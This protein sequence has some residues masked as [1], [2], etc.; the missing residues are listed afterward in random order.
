M[1]KFDKFDYAFKIRDKSNPKDWIAAEN[2]TIL[3]A[4]K[5]LG[6]SFLEDLAAR[7]RGN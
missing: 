5:D 1:Q 3:P 6:S 2:L 4:E 7:F